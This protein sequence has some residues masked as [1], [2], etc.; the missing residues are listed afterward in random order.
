L[1]TKDRAAEKLIPN[2]PDFAIAHRHAGPPFVMP[3]VLIA[4]QQVELGGAVP[5]AAF[6][7]EE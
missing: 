6:R 2:V 1:E 5:R 3:T 7:H 4:L